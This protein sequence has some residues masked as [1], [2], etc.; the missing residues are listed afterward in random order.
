MLWRCCRFFLVATAQLRK[1]WLT[2]HDN[3]PHNG[4]VTK[5]HCLKAVLPKCLDRNSMNGLATLNSTV[6]R[7]ISAASKRINFGTDCS[8]VDDDVRILNGGRASFVSSSD[9][10]GNE[11][12]PRS[13]L[14]ILPLVHGQC[15]FHSL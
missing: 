9:I 13:H 15:G 8:V 5:K 3:I 7:I 1:P 6:D 14:N 11:T 4:H 12:C 2:P 10:V